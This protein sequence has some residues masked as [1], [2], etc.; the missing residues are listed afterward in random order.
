MFGKMGLT[1]LVEA[2][3]KKNSER[4]NK[5]KDRIAGLEAE[6]AQ[7]TAKIEATTRQLV[8][9]ELAGNDAGQAKCQKQIRE[10]Q[11][12]LD[13]VQGLAQA[14]RA[15]LQKAG[16]DKKDLEAIRTA[17]QRERETRFRKFEELRAERE[18]VRQ[19]IKQLESKLEQLDREIDAAKTKKEARALMAIA[20]FID[21]RIEKLPSY[22]HEQFLDYWIA[23]QDEAMEQAL[24]RYARPEEPERRITYLNQPE[25]IVHA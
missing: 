15:E 22:E 17:A 3:Q 14:Y 16:Y 11:L 19:Q 2:F 12:E 10:L 21:P 6:A 20:T 24:A 5:I 7:I 8:D 18:N 23:G 1:E 25:K 9:C 13:R 4:R